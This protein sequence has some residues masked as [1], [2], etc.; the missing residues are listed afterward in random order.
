[1]L[2]TRLTIEHSFA[3]VLVTYGA[4]LGSGIA[5]A[6]PVTIALVVQVRPL[7]SYISSSLAFLLLLTHSHSLPHFLVLRL[8]HR[9]VVP[10]VA[11]DGGRLH[12]GRLRRRRACVQPGADPLHQPA[13]SCARRARLL[14]AGATARQFRASEHSGLRL[15]WRG[16]IYSSEIRGGVSV[17]Q[18]QYSIF[19]NAFAE[20]GARARSGRVPPV[21]LHLRAASDRGIRAHLAQSVQYFAE[22]P[23]YTHTEFTL[24]ALEYLTRSICHLPV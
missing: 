16:R 21:W 13:Q 12:P 6:Y 1:M 22:D 23:T 11:R 2:V 17:Y 5:I 18:L 4:L 20:G 8:V 10:E 19:V 9:L 7:Q 15:S 14:H 24:L 3:L